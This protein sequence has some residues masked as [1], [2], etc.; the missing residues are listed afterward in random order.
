MRDALRQRIN[1][2]PGL[3]YWVAI[4]CHKKNIEALKM[5]FFLNMG[6][7]APY[8]GTQK[9]ILEILYKELMI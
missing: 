8:I 9:E 6:S 3:E 2:F 7:R 1:A 5:A 4:I